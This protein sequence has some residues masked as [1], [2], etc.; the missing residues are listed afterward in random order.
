MSRRDRAR[1]GRF[2][3]LG[4]AITAAGSIAVGMPARASDPAGKAQYEQYCASCHGAA[5]DGNGPV[6]AELK[7]K[8]ADLRKLAQ[9]FGSPLPK[10]RLREII[11]GRD[12]P[13]AH[14]TSAM[15]VWGEK[16][17]AD[18]P[19]SAGREPFK[20]GTILVILDYLATLQI[21]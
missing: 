5:A 13:G 9:E 10:P 20:R 7:T 8:P 1:F 15:P 12:M 4:V 19:P 2:G 17:L 3:P 16:L 21:E 6:A 14:G 18:V 11:D